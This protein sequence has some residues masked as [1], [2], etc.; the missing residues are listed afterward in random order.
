MSGSGPQLFSEYGLQFSKNRE[1]FQII[2]VILGVFRGLVG[3]FVLALVSLLFC[4]LHVNQK[5][6]EFG[7]CNTSLC[8][9]R[10]G[11]AQGQNVG[12]VRGLFANEPATTRHRT[13]K[14]VTS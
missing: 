13:L 9:I 7:R 14:T 8:S 5:D 11:S 1:K 12:V 2:T 6:F 4:R 3:V 10:A